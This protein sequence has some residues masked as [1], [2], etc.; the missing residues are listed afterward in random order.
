MDLDQFISLEPA[1]FKKLIEAGYLDDHG[2]WFVDVYNALI[3]RAPEH[4]AHVKQLAASAVEA[5]LGSG[6][7]NVSTSSKTQ[8]C[9]SNA[10]LVWK[11]MPVKVR[12]WS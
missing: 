1:A 3:E 7:L 5:Y 10:S 2:I 8:L 9:L 4:P 12:F 11:A 6:L